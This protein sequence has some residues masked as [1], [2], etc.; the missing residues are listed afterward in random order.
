MTPWE[1]RGRELVNCNCAYGC[2]CQFNALPT[3]GF[4]EAVGAFA[5]D[6][7]FHGDVRLDGL[8]M[9]VAVR[10][11][12]PIHEGKGRCQPIVDAKADVW[13]REA[14]LK[15]MSGQDTDPFATMFAV[16]ATTFEKLFDPIFVPIE[17]EA[18][19]EA[20]KGRVRAGDILEVRG[21]PIKNPITGQ[22]HRARIE[23][24]EGFEYEVAEIGS[25]SGHAKGNVAV[26]L[27]DTYAQFAHLHL[28]NH[29]VVRHRRHV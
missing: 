3:H 21:E 12:G 2:P 9:A 27:K 8:A 4:C 16:F 13:Q 5:V 19:I 15:I 14:L 18:D 10:W 6:E 7:G 1:I 28:N 26:D 29:G 25:A 20:R 24:P 23:L 22:E 11:P 17:F